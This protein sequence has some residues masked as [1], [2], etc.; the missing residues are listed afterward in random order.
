MP[1]PVLSY[2]S[3]SKRIQV[4][5]GFFV[6][7]ASALFGLLALHFALIYWQLG[8]PTRSSGWA[9][10]INQ[11]KLRK[12]ASIPGPKLL[13]V[14]GSATLF[15][16]QAE[17]IEASLNYPTVNLGT[18]AGLGIA[19]MTHLAKQAARPGDTVVLAFEYSTYRF[20]LVR[21]DALYIDYLLARDPAF[22]RALPPLGKFQVAMMVTM[23]RLRKGIR[24]RFRP[25][26]PPK[27]AP[28][29]DA[30]KLNAH[31]DQ[32]GHE[33]VN[34]PRTRPRFYFPDQALAQGLPKVL[35][36]FET[37]AEFVAWAR[38]NDVRVFATYP[39]IMDHPL[40]HAAA[41]PRTLRQLREAYADLKVPI[42][43]RFEEAMLKPSAFLDTCY[44][45]TREGA[46]T[47]TERLIPHLAAE[48]KR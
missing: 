25:E 42:I 34:R 7:I 31:G 32:L 47:R 48:L 24:N 45:L 4:P 22:F 1:Q 37:I 46:R 29:Y 8:V 19:Y 5:R 2:T 44:H 21:E 14:G 35:P 17:L 9:Y 38:A 20:G 36:A 10:E 41:A 3:T 16:I 43:G 13:L 12:A 30:S 6:G 27:P 23:P 11:K 15:G 26:G 18:H 39:N 28:L 40:Y 33:A